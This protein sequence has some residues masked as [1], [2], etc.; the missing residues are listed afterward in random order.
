[1]P[2]GTTTFSYRA[3]TPDGHTLIGRIDAADS[4]AALAALRASKL[5]VTSVE[6][7]PE[8]ETSEPNGQGRWIGPAAAADFDTFNQQFASLAESG[9]PV[10]AALRIIAMDMRRGR[11]R[12]AVV[13][14]RQEV[15][16]G[17]S[18]PE[19]FD[20]HARAFPRGYAVMIEA[21]I[22][23]NNLPGVL[24]GLSRH[25]DLRARMS[26]AVWRAAAYPLMVLLVMVLVL[27]F[28]G[29]YILPGFEPIFRDF[30]TEMPAFT[31]F[32]LWLTDFTVPFVVVSLLVIIGGPLAWRYMRWTIM[33]RWIND[34]VFLKLPLIGR[35]LR[36]SHVARWCDTLRLGVLASKGLD[37]AIELAAWSSDSLQVKGDSARLI[38]SV[39]SG[40][41]LTDVR[42]MRVVPHALVVSLDLAGRGPDLAAAMGDLTRLYE[43]EAEVRLASLQ[44][45]LSPLL[46]LFLALVLGS[47]TV[48]M[49]LPL[50][51]LIQSVV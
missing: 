3:Q 23:A 7:E 22:A 42:G 13:A 14:V 18:L 41:P 16:N 45:V 51:K 25:L 19:A 36:A 15:E 27:G 12:D 47:F 30:D 28:V 1:M 39:R 35:G 37:E 21:G 32:T 46:L 5:T 43:Q 26:A 20:R 38:E 11:L 29:L 48:A 8:P 40:E 33:P 31:Q 6:P 24:M 50:V 34:H 4:E 17:A 10:D 9:L 2:G 49:F 44:V